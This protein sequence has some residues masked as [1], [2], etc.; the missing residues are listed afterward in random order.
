MERHRKADNR[1]PSIDE[2]MK[3]AAAGRA[4]ALYGRPESVAAARAVVDEARH[5]R[6]DVTLPDAEEF[7]EEAL[8]RAKA[9]ATPHMK[10]VFN[11]TGVILHTNLGRAVLAEEAVA[12][13]VIAMRHPVSLEFDLETGERGERD[14]HI[15]ELVCELTGAADATVVNNNAAALF[16][17]LNTLARGR[18]TVVSRGELIEIGGS[19][20]LPAIM[21]RAETLLVEVGTTNRTHVSDYVSAITDQTG[22]LLKVHTSNYVVKGFT[23]SV[24]VAEIA[25]IAREANLPSLYD[26]GS[27][28]LLNVEK[29]G[30]TH[31]PTVADIVNAGVDLVTFSGDKL[32]GGPQVGFIAGRKD[33]IAAINRN[34]MKRAMRLDKIRMAALEA[35]LRLYRDPDRLAERLPTYR[36][37]R[38]SRAELRE[39]ARLVL[40]AVQQPL[41]ASFDVEVVDCEGEIGSGAMPTGKIPSAGLAIRP[42]S[43]RGGKALIALAAALRSLPIA[44]IGRIEGGALILDLRCLD[45]TAAFSANMMQLWRDGGPTAAS[46]ARPKPEG[47]RIAT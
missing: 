10:H 36:L 18:G 24:G 23:K 2:I 4:C 17:V 47:G 13:A 12:A 34:P 19:F 32:L 20:R 25:S 30:L 27:G 35:T 29:F 22:L 15:R 28:V 40:P 37:I 42:R 16:L 21:E 3:T 9:N 6:H 31:E 14:D 26:M 44:V 39:M 1:I 11:L 41:A 46:A 45:D 38:R 33:L 5:R 7:G 43:G 8:A